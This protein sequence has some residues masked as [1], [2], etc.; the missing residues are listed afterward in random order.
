MVGA[1]TH[2]CK[3]SNVPFC[4]DHLKDRKNDHEISRILLS[5]DKLSDADRR[6]GSQSSKG[7]PMNR[8]ESIEKFDGSE[9]LILR[10]L[11]NVR[12]ACHHPE[13]HVCQQE[14]SNK[15][16]L[17]WPLPWQTTKTTHS[18]LTHALSVMTAISELK[19]RCCWRAMIPVMASL[20][21]IREQ[22]KVHTTCACLAE[23]LFGASLLMT[24]E[25]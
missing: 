13:R 2:L 18:Q 24:S 5:I 12:R 6:F 1:A 25:K 19:T 15:W 10:P 9:P 3:G 22:R 21:S 23:R 14:L 7:S 20:S 17:T 16:F 8:H 11:A 4:Y